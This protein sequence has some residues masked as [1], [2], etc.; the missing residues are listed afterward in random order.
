M[1]IKL[2]LAAGIVS[3][4]VPGASAAPRV[5]LL[6]VYPGSTGVE[7]QAVRMRLLIEQ[8]LSTTNELVMLPRQYIKSALLRSGI[9]TTGC[10]DIK[11]RVEECKATGADALMISTLA[12]ANGRYVLAGGIF[13]CTGGNFT[14]W[15]HVAQADIT[16]LENEL[17][18]FVDRL[19]TS[20]LQVYNYFLLILDVIPA[21]A[22]VSTG[23]RNFTPR[24]GRV[25]IKLEKGRNH[26]I[27][28]SREGYEPY[29]L[30]VQPPKKQYHVHQHV[31][32]QPVQSV[33]PQ[34]NGYIRVETEPPGA[35]V[36][37][38]ERRMPSLTPLTISRV[39]PGVHHLTIV[40]EGY[41]TVRLTVS[42]RNDRVTPVKITMEPVQRTV[43]VSTHPAGAR[44]L[45]DGKFLGTSP[46]VFSIGDE[47]SHLLEVFLPGYA[48]GVTVIAPRETN[49]SIMLSPLSGQLELD[50]SGAVRVTVDGIQTDKKGRLQLPGGTHIVTF[51]D[52]RGVEKVQTVIIENG[53]K[54]F[55][56]SGISQT[57]SFLDIETEPPGALVYVDGA[58]AGNSPLSA[59]SVKEGAHTLFIKDPREFHRPLSMTV[60]VAAGERKRVHASLTPYPASISIATRPP[61][62]LVFLDGTK[63]GT[64]PLQLRNVA[65]G[66][67][68]LR[69]EKK[70]YV[71][72]EKKITLLPYQSAKMALDFTPIEASVEYQQ[73]LRKRRLSATIWASAGGGLL[74][75]AVSFYLAAW[76]YASSAADAN[77]RYRLTTIPN[78]MEK[79]KA[80][81]RDRAQLAS[82]FNMAGHFLAAAATIC[83]GVSAYY[84]FTKPQIH[85]ELSLQPRA[86][87]IVVGIAW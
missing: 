53:K 66:P 49:I 26:V 35:V 39:A 25:D 38:N 46:H 63:T 41:Y 82:G 33:L 85:I 86:G 4:W 14:S 71:P 54:V 12:R 8:H 1:K 77:N 22:S 15:N 61:G 6:D 55:L 19:T 69:F 50:I 76:H 32:L 81:A 3:V 42:V 24:K 13:E 84:Y 87:T 78:E 56:K 2:L 17:P 51:S 29:E 80:T 30:N 9:S 60:R 43:K 21:D 23:K 5:A 36:F 18:A 58:L 72:V 44:L 31:R 74:L 70:G 37:F 75:G 47:E 34:G 40:K 52:S 65:A 73:A 67:H 83:G 7:A 10:A 57:A 11:C 68:R 62:A 64:S 28:I 20:F 16:S 79:W 45:L 48:P 59:I 27:T